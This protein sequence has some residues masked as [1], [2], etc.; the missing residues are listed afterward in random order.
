MTEDEILAREAKR[1][2]A[3]CDADAAALDDVFH[4]DLKYTH[5]SGALDTKASYS[6]GVLDGLWDYQ[7]VTPREQ[8]VTIVG[9]AAT[10]H[11]KLRID[12]IVGG[13]KRTVHSVAM[14]VWAEDGGKWQCI[15]VHSTPQAG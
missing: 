5:S 3:M 9:N 15:A 12:V 11:C 8:S 13:E 6:K 10:I 14:S 7:A 1:F 2:K 4:R